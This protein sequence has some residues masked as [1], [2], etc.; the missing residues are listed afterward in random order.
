M[1]ALRC[2]ALQDSEDSEPEDSE[3]A[4]DLSREEEAADPTPLNEE[5]GGHTGLDWK[6]AGRGR[7]VLHV[8]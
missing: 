2:V 5:V 8:S 3:P 1:A 6:A 4:E 7:S